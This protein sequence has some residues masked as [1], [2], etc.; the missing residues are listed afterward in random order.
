MAA[1]AAGERAAAAN[2]NVFKAVIMALL[3]VL[4][5]ASSLAP[6]WISQHGTSAARNVLTRKLPFV[7]AGV[8]I[9]ASMRRCMRLVMQD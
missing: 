7:T 4:T 3:F 9:G 1:A 6:L 2:A 5:V 8:F